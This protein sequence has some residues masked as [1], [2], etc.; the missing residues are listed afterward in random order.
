MNERLQVKNA[1]LRVMPRDSKLARNE[2][3]NSIQKTLVVVFY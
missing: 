1:L 3:D 2:H